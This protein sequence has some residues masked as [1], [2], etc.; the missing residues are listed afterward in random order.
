MSLTMRS[1]ISDVAGV[2]SEALERAG[3]RTVLSGGACASIHSQGAYESVDL[4]FI[5][6]S[7]ATQPAIE[8]TLAQEG[9][10]R[11]GDQYFHDLAPY[12]IE[13]PP[14]P[15]AIGSD[16]SI[17]PI[18]QKV[19]AFHI[20]MLSATDSCRDRLAAAFHWRDAAA[21]RAAVEIAL[22]NEVNF[23]TIKKWSESERSLDKYEAFL[24]EV[25]KSKRRR[26]ARGRT[27]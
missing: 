6:Q 21:L 18:V 13:F 7:A 27:R 24:E 22:R 25:E 19:G 1:S 8:R 5:V 16:Y 14:G 15:I 26:R 10:H 2:V 9:F 3:I 17:A 12:Y 20:R 23:H 11:R 4:D